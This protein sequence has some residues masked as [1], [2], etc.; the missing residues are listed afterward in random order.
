MNAKPIIYGLQGAGEK[1]ELLFDVPSRL[2]GLLADGVVDVALIP[3][4]GCLFGK[5]LI[6][7][8]GVCIA[9]YGR[10]ESVRLFLRGCYIDDVR[11]VALDESSRTS[12]VLTR[13]I[14]QEKYGIS[15]RYF[16]WQAGS[17]MEDAQADA[18]LVIGD[19]AMRIDDGLPSLDLGAE[20]HEFAGLPFVYALWASAS[21]DVLD[22]ATN[23]LQGAKERGLEDLGAI[24][25]K[26]SASLGL[27]PELCMR[28]LTQCIRYDFGEEELR[29]LRRF[30][31]YA[32]K[33]GLAPE[34]VRFELYD[35]EH[36]REGALEEA[37]RA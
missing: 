4:I 28:Y 14:L 19:N 24:A 11:S 21:R 17:R 16:S 6:A 8:P 34:G 27:E 33:M 18:V 35:G 20:W 30:Y 37:D 15:P 22:E 36:I 3:S 13:I 5:G 26:E 1:T 2:P 29:G 12:A 23:L 7:L 31:D 32:R 10:V 25:L 9:S